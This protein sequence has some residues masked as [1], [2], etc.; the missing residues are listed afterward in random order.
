[1]EREGKEKRRDVEKKRQ[2]KKSKRQRHGER[3]RR[4]GDS[5]KARETERQQEKET[6]EQKQRVRHEHR[7][8]QIESW[9]DR[10]E[11]EAEMRREE[12]SPGRDPGAYV[13]GGHTY[14]PISFSAQPPT[15]GQ[16]FSLSTQWVMGA[17]GLKMAFYAISFTLTYRQGN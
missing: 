14:R 2:E 3:E 1:M 8:S 17:R 6:Q 16:T 7:D 5:K 10:K 15:P 9:R 12:P 13:G 11:M 4:N